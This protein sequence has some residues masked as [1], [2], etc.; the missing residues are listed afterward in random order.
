MLHFVTVLWKRQ[1]WATQHT[2]PLTT[3]TPLMATNRLADIQEKSLHAIK[4]AHSQYVRLCCNESFN[5]SRPPC[6]YR[7]INKGRCTI[8]SHWAE[9]RNPAAALITPGCRRALQANKTSRHSHNRG[10]QVKC[11]QGIRKD[12]VTGKNKLL[13]KNVVNS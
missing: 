7:C 13:Q 2:H 5:C 6:K 8:V 3:M 9:P 10:S 11:S 12:P 1:H 4:A